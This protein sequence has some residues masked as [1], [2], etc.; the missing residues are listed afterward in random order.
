MDI[1]IHSTFV[2]QALKGSIG[3]DG[4]GLRLMCGNRQMRTKEPVFALTRRQ[5]QDSCK[6][7]IL[8]PTSASAYEGTIL[9]GMSASG[10]CHSRST[11][12]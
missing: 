9:S 1:N 5:V 8:K 3:R 11:L 10:V 6:V 4:R 2:G 7:R 12:C